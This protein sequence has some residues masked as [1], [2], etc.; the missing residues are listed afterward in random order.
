[1]ECDFSG[2]D[3]AEADVVAIVE[4]DAAMADAAHC[5]RQQLFAG[6]VDVE[7]RC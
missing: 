1:M 3:A 2:I 4:V 6:A 7:R 5:S